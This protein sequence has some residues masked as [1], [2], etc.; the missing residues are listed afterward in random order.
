MLEKNIVQY[1]AGTKEREQAMERSETC[2][3]RE[4]ERAINLS[5]T[6]AAIY[7]LKHVQSQKIPP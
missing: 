5:C 1:K 3:E 4:D 2:A 7:L 6:A